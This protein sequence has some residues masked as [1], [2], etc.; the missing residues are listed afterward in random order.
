[1]GIGTAGLNICTALVAHLKRNLCVTRFQKGLASL[2]FLSLLAASVV[3]TFVQSK[4]VDLVNTHGNSIG[5]YASGGAQYMVFTWVAVVLMLFGAS[6]E[7]F[8]DK[9]ASW[10]IPR[11]WPGVYESGYGP[12]YLKFRTY[13]T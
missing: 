1:V 5:V 12:E 3:I 8:G 7:L 11:T 4:A 10:N 2:A 6:A 9:I 13:S